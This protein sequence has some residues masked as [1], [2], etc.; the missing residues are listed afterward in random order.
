MFVFL[1]VGSGLYGS[2]IANR[3]KA[4]GKSVLL[5]EK[6]SHIAGNIFTEKIEGV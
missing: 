3:L 1:V 5:I 4:S 6:R 2:V